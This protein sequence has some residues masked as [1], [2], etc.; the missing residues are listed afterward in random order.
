MRQV[1]IQNRLQGVIHAWNET[2]L[3]LKQMNKLWEWSNIC[4]SSQ[5]PMEMPIHEYLLRSAGAGGGGG[6]REGRHPWP[7]SPCTNVRSP[8]F[9][10]ICPVVRRPQCFPA[11]L[12]CRGVVAK[13]AQCQC[14]ICGAEIGSF[15][16]LC[17]LWA[18]LPPSQAFQTP[19]S[20][21]RSSTCSPFYVSTPVLLSGRSCAAAVLFW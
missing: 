14:H 20:S 19:L 11:S 15:W 17:T 1:L 4:F 16:S 9:A 7:Q 13:V 12:E 6:G 10:T 3:T 5:V 2:A 18:L 8:V 21:G